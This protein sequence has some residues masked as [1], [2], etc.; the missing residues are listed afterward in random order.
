LNIQFEYPIAFWLLLILPLLLLMFSFYQL[1]KRK[2]IKKIGDP[3][4]VQSL[5]KNHSVKR[6][7]LKF[8]FILIAF[9]LGILALANPRKP[10]KSTRDQRVG[11][12]VMIALDVSSSMLATDVPPVRLQ[13]AQNLLN[14]LIDRMPN[15]R[16]GIILFAGRGYLQMP[17]SMDH[18]A[19]KLFI[20]TAHPDAIPEKG[21]AIADAF[22][23]AELAFDESLRFK[24]I[25]LVTDGETHDEDALK[26]AKRLAESG[27]M[28]NT[29]GIGSTQGSIIIDTATKSA[30]RDQSGNVIMSKLNEQLLQEIASV[31]NGTYVHYNSVESAVNA[32]L[33]QYR[34]VDKKALEDKTALTYQ[35]FYYWAVLPMLL[36]L[37]FEFFY[38][39]KKRSKS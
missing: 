31:T 29:V 4:L 25:I 1:W 20:R 24:T 30:K 16:F 21:T 7:R 34:D 18:G 5:I 17:L 35:S 19:A 38:S 3:Q 12:D 33:L 28:I 2:T 9:A 10:D 15:D 14:T 36:L 37:L 26:E 11:I 23:Q 22:K 13:N 27:I 32:L 39:D 6:E 8:S